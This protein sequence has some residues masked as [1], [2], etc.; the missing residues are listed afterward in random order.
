[1]LGLTEFH[2]FMQNIITQKL[3]QHPSIES[4]LEHCIITW[5]LHQHPNIS[6][7]PEHHINIRQ[8]INTLKCILLWCIKNLSIQQ[9]LITMIVNIKRANYIMLCKSAYK[10]IQLKWS[11]YVS[12]RRCQMQGAYKSCHLLFVH[13]NAI[14]ASMQFCNFF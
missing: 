11:M 8:C 9:C 1:M 10:T 14:T 5:T 3:H 2:Y 7:T 13:T 6:S 12:Y 4:T